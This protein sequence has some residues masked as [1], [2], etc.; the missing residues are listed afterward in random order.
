LPPELIVEEHA[1][2]RSG[3]GL[4][5]AVLDYI[6]SGRAA[7]IQGRNDDSNWWYILSPNTQAPCWISGQLVSL[8][9]DT[10]LIP[11]IPV[12]PVIPI[13]TDTPAFNC[14]QYNSDPTGCETTAGN[15]CRWNPNI[16]P[17]GACVNR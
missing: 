2:C 14:A 6:E 10:S 4:D 7:L 13:I 8:P 16:A 1:S 9:E 15:T 12:I 5:Y 11:V 3:P 17:N